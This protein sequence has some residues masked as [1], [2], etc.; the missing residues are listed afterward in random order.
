MD[1]PDPPGVK[2]MNSTK[3]LT[4]NY[5]IG[6]ASIENIKSYL[7]IILSEVWTIKRRELL[8]EAGQENL[9]VLGRSAGD[10]RDLLPGDRND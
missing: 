7:G 6:Q 9:R 8:S 10:I 1:S 2:K 4:K 3:N 5:K